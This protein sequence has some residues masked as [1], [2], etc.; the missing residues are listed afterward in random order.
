MLTGVPEVV[1]TNAIQKNL[2]RG[3][4]VEGNDER[5]RNGLWYGGMLSVSQ[6]RIWGSDGR[7][8]TQRKG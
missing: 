4:R 6:R 5:G 3:L 1:A 2:P 8:I 7:C